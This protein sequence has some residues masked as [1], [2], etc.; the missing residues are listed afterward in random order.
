M[1]ARSIAAW[2]RYAHA[3]NRGESQA[4]CNIYRAWYLATL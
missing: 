4:V 3:C 2:N 1:S